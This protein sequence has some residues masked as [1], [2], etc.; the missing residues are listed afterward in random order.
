M[1]ENIGE[2]MP[3]RHERPVFCPGSIRSDFVSFRYYYDILTASTVRERSEDLFGIA[4]LAANPQCDQYHQE[5]S[6][7]QYQHYA[8]NKRQPVREEGIEKLTKR[9]DG[10]NKHS[11]MPSLRCI[12]VVVEDHQALNLLRAQESV[13]C[14][15]DLPA[16]TSEPANN[17]R[18]ELLARP[19]RK[20]ANPVVL[21]ASRRRPGNTLVTIQGEGLL[22][23]HIDAISA[24]DTT[25]AEKP[26]KVPMY[27]HIRPAVPPLMRPNMF[28]FYC[29]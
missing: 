28:A 16:E 19:R 3:M 26:M 18:Q 9:D 5:A 2:S 15:S 11:E 8:L 4:R 23:P 6:D 7:V 12:I 10:D 1:K 24:I 13:G 21:S 17:V 25:A 14:I 20:L 27:I 29:C 22:Q